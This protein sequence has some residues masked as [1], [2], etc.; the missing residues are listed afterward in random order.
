MTRPSFLKRVNRDLLNFTDKNGV[1]SLALIII[2]SAFQ[3]L[4]LYLL[5]S[6]IVFA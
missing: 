3:S 4:Y 1:P 2:D 6:E 5:W